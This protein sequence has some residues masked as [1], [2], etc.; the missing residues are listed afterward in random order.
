VTRRNR[1]AAAFV[2]VLLTAAVVADVPADVGRLFFSKSERAAFE[3]ARRAVETEP[4]VKPVETL[5]EMAPDIVEPE[6][7]LIRPVITVDGYVRRSDGEATVWVNGENNYD[8]DL[9]RSY[10][11]PAA[12][13]LRGTRVT[14][15]PVDTAAAVLL[16]PGQSYDPNAATATDLYQ[17]AVGNSQSAPE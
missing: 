13:R 1:I 2:G 14:V 15:V 10:I 7:E 6:P 16:K 12:T 9:A 5:P 11:D 4:G 17:E 8:G 3:R